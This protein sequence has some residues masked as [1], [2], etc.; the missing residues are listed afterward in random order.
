MCEKKYAP[1]TTSE[2]ESVSEGEHEGRWSLGHSFGH[3]KVRRYPRLCFHQVTFSID[4]IMT[5]LMSDDNLMIEIIK[6]KTYE[7]RMGFIVTQGPKYQRLPEGP[8]Y[9][10]VTHPD[11]G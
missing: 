3:C 9:A 10:F 5:I 2:A 8:I 11:E 4:V 1:A 7:G 6:K